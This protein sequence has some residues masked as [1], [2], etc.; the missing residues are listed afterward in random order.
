[1]VLEVCDV[2]GT[3]R[4]LILQLTSLLKCKEDMVLSSLTSVINCRSIASKFRRRLS[5]LNLNLTS[6]ETSKQ[7]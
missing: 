2:D 5:V 1:M 3:R 6:L 4:K 7:S